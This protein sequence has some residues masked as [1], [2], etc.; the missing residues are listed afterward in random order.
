MG[1]YLAI[2]NLELKNKASCST[3]IRLGFDE[4]LIAKNKVRILC[5][6]SSKFINDYC[7]ASN[8]L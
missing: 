6:N 2:N 7:N 5:I 1:V 4:R 3:F 8:N